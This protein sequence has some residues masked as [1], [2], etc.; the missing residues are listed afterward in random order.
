MWQVFDSLFF[1]FLLLFI[2]ILLLQQ[3]LVEVSFPY[4]FGFPPFPS[5][6]FTPTAS[7]RL[8]PLF[9]PTPIISDLLSK[10]PNVGQ[11]ESNNVL[12]LSWTI[13]LRWKPCGKSLILIIQCPVIFVHIHAFGLRCI[14]HAIIALSLIWYNEYCLTLISNFNVREPLHWDCWSTTN[15]CSLSTVCIFRSSFLPLTRSMEHTYYKETP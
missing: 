3:I 10:S 5:P 8:P 1:Y 4:L 2:N 11:G 12:N 9:T 14:K 7:H 15:L 13:L 6:L